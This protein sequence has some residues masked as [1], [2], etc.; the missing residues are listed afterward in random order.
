LQRKISLA[1][2]QMPVFNGNNAV[3]DTIP[4]SAGD[5]TIY[6]YDSASGTLGG[7]ADGDS[8]GGGAGNDFIYGGNGNDTIDGGAGS[9]LIYGGFGADSISAGAGQ[10]QVYSY[11]LEGPDTLDGGADRDY[12]WLDRTSFAGAITA[13]FSNPAVQ[14]TLADGTRVVNLEQVHFFSGA[15]ADSIT[16]SNYTY[17]DGNAVFGG[18]GND[19]LASGF[20]GAYLRGGAGDDRLTGLGD[21]DGGDGNDFISVGKSATLVAGDGRG[22][23]GNDT[24]VGSGPGLVRLYGDAGDDLIDMTAGA[25]SYHIL[26]GGDGADTI[27]GSAGDENISGG[28]GADSVSAGG[29]SDTVSSY[30]VDGPDTSDGGAGIDLLYADL[31]S[32]AAGFGADLSNSATL[33]SF[34]DGTRFV[35]FEAVNFIAGAGNDT[36]TS[37]NSNVV[38]NVYGGGGNDSLTGSANGAYLSGDAGNDTL[39]SGAG[40]DRLAGGV[41]DDTYVVNGVGDTIFEN[42]LEGTDTV[43]TSLAYYVLDAGN[44]LENVTFTSGAQLNIGGGNGLNNAFVGASGSDGF[45]GGGGADSYNSGA[46][47]DYLYIDHFDT[48]INAGAG[49]DAVFVQ[50]ATGVNLNLGAAQVEWVYAWTGNDTLNASTSTVGVA[51]FGEAGADVISGSA[52]NDYVYF[53]GLDF[54]NAGAGRDALFYYQGTGQALANLNLNVAAANAEYVIVGAGNDTLFNTGSSTAVSLLGGAGNDTLTGGLGN[55]YL[56][57]DLGAGNFGNDV[58]VVTNNAQSDVILDFANGAD[59][60][61]VHNTGFATFAQIQAAATDNG[62]GAVIN[63]GGGNTVTLYNFALGNLDV[64]DIIF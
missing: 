15:G 23:N 5:D 39:V 50:D 41:G 22:G 6:G 46:G 36:V 8:L 32:L 63:F 28:P 4:G 7:F 13:D 49:Y 21:F 16:A 64:S 11:D 29:G 31:S 14:L 10:D 33:Q 24:L 40:N 44:T 62:F 17:S 19:T 3:S 60:L 51:L 18:G 27:L 35:N 59:R 57:G 48:A 37:S 55:D 25:A 2:A 20:N 34:A 61:N 43:Q 54:I 26:Q 45:T 30:A 38:N 52:F 12:L 1:E 47:D 42:A 58:F 9:D 56:Y 53:D